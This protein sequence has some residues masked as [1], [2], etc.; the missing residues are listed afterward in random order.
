MTIKHKII[1]KDVKVVCTVS[2]AASMAFTFMVMFCDERLI[3]P[4]AYIMSHSIF[5]Y[6]IL[7]KKMFNDNTKRYTIKYSDS[8]AAKLGHN[9]EFWYIFSRMNDDKEY[10]EE[11]M[12]KY[13]IATKILKRPKRLGEKGE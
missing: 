6:G 3:L 11:E 1:P 8:E 2:S 10:T 13:G 7:F 4:D 5:Y 12:L 9:K